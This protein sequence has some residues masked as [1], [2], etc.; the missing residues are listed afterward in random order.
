MKVLLLAMPDISAQFHF[1]VR[2]PNLALVNLAGNLPGHEV[3]VLDLVLTRPRV[4]QALERTL[5]EFRPRVV[6]LS[7]MSYQFATLL[8]LARRVLQFDPAIKLV[9]GGYHPTFLARQFTEADPSLPLDFLVRGEG[10]ATFRE[11]VEEMSRPQPD[12]SHI[13]GLSYRQGDAWLHNP[14]R[15]LQDLAELP[16]P[17]R[18][19][20]LAQDFFFLNLPWDVAETSRGCP[21]LC[22][23]CS[24]TLMYG[25]TFRRFPIPRII[26]DLEDIRRR[27]AKGVFFVDDNIT[28]D[29]EH[30]TEVCR[31]IIKHGLT[32][33]AYV[34]QAS[35]VGLAEHPEVVADM[36]RANFQVV[37]VGFESMNPESLSDLRKPTSPQINRRA[38]SLLR[39][40][41]ISCI[42]AAV[43]G[44]PSDTAQS[45]H[46]SYLGLRSLRPDLV[47]A[48]FLTPYPGTV[49]RR[50]LEE[51]GLITN[52]DDFSK[53]DGFLC[54]IRTR[55]LSNAELFH[56]LKTAALKSFFDPRM[57]M[58]NA[59]IKRHGL[60]FL[61]A[62][63]KNLGHTLV[64]EVLLGRRAQSVMDL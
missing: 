50:E 36:A 24:I 44:Q 52:L 13:L 7:A 61:T 3:R 47:I 40:H 54:N 18:G 56:A 23:F 39:Q 63:L 9:A 51:E 26:A 12:F 38:A 62:I 4:R 11:L 27:G 29:A 59:L 42:A 17:D 48:Q 6:G 41:G 2:F 34:T 45:I 1:F 22:K 35:A 19:T 31:A 49:L 53:Y 33:L 64:H 32:D 20:R 46:R 30:L 60:A 14:D 57:I 58:G 5:A 25:H 28:S 55:H 15:P 16:L 8:T 37:L 21:Y 43:F 10:E